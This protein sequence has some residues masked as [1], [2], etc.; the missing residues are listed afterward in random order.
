MGTLIVVCFLGVC[1]AEEQTEEKQVS[2]SVKVS[3]MKAKIDSIL[4]DF[5]SSRGKRNVQDCD[6]DDI[7]DLN[8]AAKD[9]SDC[10]DA[11]ECCDRLDDTIDELEDLDGDC[12][13]LI[14]NFDEELDELKDDVD[15]VCGSGAALTVG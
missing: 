15:R 5:N 11:D 12:K 7:D 9:L 2:K 8:D 6:E 10:D 14:R 13:D 1:F 3:T 4:K